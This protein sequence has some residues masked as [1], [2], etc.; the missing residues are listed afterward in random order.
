MKFEVDGA[1]CFAAGEIP[2]DHTGPVVVLV[3]GAA[4]DHSVWVYHTRYFRHRRVA[5]VAPDLPGHGRSDGDALGSIEAIAAWLARMLD[6]LGVTEARVAGHSMGALAAL[7]LAALDPARVTRLAL[8]GAAV[9]MAVSAPLLDAARENKPQA[10]DMMM[11]WGHGPTAQI[12]GN[13][14]A[15]VNIVKSGMRLLERA[16]PG[17]LFTDLNACN[18][19]T[20]GPAAAARVTAATRLICGRDDKMTPARAARELQAAID[21]CEIETIADCGHILMSEQPEQT[22]RALVGALL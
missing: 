9:P 6:V 11:L 21:H 7:E 22:H 3:H 16:R 5:V 13:A 8:L 4:M 14:V 17:V 15:G 2:A 12:G 1:A 19:Y 18:E 10:R 20:E